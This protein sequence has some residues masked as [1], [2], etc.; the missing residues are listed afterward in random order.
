MKKNRPFK[1][2]TRKIGAVLVPAILYL[3]MRLI[4]LSSRKRFHYIT[5]I[6][7][8]QYVCV[9]WHSELFMTPLAYRRIH[10]KHTVNAIIS[11]HFDGELIAGTLGYMGVKSMRGSSSK[12]AARV[13]L[14]AL[15][16][17]EAG[18]EVMISPDGPR[19]PRY[20]MSEGAIALAQKLHLPIFIINYT[21]SR[22]WQLRSWDRFVIPKP[23]STID[24]Y[25]QGVSVGGMESEEAKSFLREKMLEHA[26]A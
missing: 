4:W 6:T 20:H 24:F 21:A 26:F 18:E 19:G 5:P 1:T 7:Q 2:F 23:F 12:G 8:E 14:Q 22:C 3:L 13:L 17:M 25:I 9:C 11:Q 16:A 15:K 10:P